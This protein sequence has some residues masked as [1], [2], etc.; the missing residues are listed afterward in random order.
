MTN[1]II[2]VFLL[3]LHSIFSQAQIFLNGKIVDKSSKQPVAYA[4]ISINST[5]G[6]ASNENGEFHLKIEP[7]YLNQYVNISCIGYSTVLFS[8]ASSCLT[9]ASFGA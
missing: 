3:R 4:N 7:E 2:L 8:I 6:T 9:K 5:I 1:R